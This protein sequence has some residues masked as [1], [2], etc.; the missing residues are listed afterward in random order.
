MKAWKV[1]VDQFDSAEFESEVQ[2]LI[3]LVLDQDRARN[4]KIRVSSN[5]RKLSRIR[6]IVGNRMNRKDGNDVLERSV[7]VGACC[8][9]SKSRNGG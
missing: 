3:G 8:D 1:E 6:I 4:R 2:N 5:I 9:G 7:C